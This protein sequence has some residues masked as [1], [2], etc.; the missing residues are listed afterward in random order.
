[1]RSSLVGLLAGEKKGPRPA[2][3]AKAGPR[4]ASECLV[5]AGCRRSEGAVAWPVGFYFSCQRASGA[6]PLL[7]L[8][9]RLQGKCWTDSH[10]KNWS[11]SSSNKTGSTCVLVGRRGAGALRGASAEGRTNVPENQTECRE[12]VM[13]AARAALEQVAG[14]EAV[15]PQELAAAIADGRGDRQAVEA[16]TRRIFGDRR[17]L[18]LVL[19]D[20]D[21]IAE[22]VYES[23]LPP[24]IAGASTILRDLNRE[25]ARLYQSQTIFSGGGEGLL[26]VE[27]GRGEGICEEIENLYWEQTDGALGVTTG[28]LE[29]SPLD[30]IAGGPQ[31]EE[32]RDGVR[33]V[34][35]TQAVLARLRDRIR[36][37][38]DEVYPQRVPVQGALPRCIS[39]R[40]R[41][42]NH[43][44]PVTREGLTGNVLCSPCHRRWSEGK[45]QIAGVSFD[46][47]I[48]TLQDA[49]PK[50]GAKSSYT[51]FLYADGNSMGALFGRLGSLTEIGFLS[52]AVS[53]VF[54]KLEELARQRAEDQLGG[55]EQPKRLFLSYLGGGDEAIW[56]V[57]GALALQ[58]A[59]DLPGWLSTEVRNIPDLPGFLR[60]R[61]VEDLTLGIGLV[62]C[63]HSYPVRYQYALAKELQK[64]AKQMFYGG[65]YRTPPS[66]IDFE[67]LTDSS[68]LVE[69]LK[70]ARDL[71]YPTEEEGFF[72]TCRPFDQERFSQLFGRMQTAREKGVATSQLHALLAGAGESRR[73]FL[74][75]LRYQIARPPAGKRYQDWL[76][77]LGTPW[78]DASRVEGFFV[79]DLLPDQEGQRAGT[80]IADGV[81]LLPFLNHLEQLGRL[82]KEAR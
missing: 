5:P 72:R 16:A 65:A 64:N 20:T 13:R 57:P 14:R 54:E 4:V 29:V 8:G 81:Q 18:D 52:R 47:L 67:L 79:H 1:M 60:E 25:L 58:I 30:F 75:Y 63:S 19:F 46:E 53:H 27:R 41:A 15:V 48:G 26:L 78:I 49:Y 50:L 56:I 32:A 68:P 71:A 62:L 7:L 44:T 6:E 37:K 77:C 9:H 73:I 21:R 12:R 61:K 59:R 10:P 38:K 39:C 33:L 80:W 22:Y 45:D 2:F 69:D 36:R 34:A 23:S 55:I 3:W 76:C 66:S 17:P 43:P 74:N 40:D 42:A 31:E 51:G 35:G 28:F 11:G 82:R 70:E 24:V